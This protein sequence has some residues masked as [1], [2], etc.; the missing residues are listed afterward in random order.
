MDD[1][2]LT[3][4]LTLRRAR[5]DELAVCAGLYVRVL[6][7][8]FTW[9]PPERH[10]A[11]DFLAAA[12]DEE[13]FVA[14]EAGRIVGMAALYRPQLFLHSLYVTERGRGIGK[15]LLDHVLAAAGGRLSLKCQAANNGAQAFYRREGFR[16][17]EA[18]EDGGVAWLRFVRG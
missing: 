5:A 6:S 18:G 9:V 17:A 7:D 13:I 16:C 2:G 8:T 3:D 15:A 4:G 14:I 10:R 1:A 11:E 12:R